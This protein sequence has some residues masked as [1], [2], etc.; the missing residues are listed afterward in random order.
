MVEE[1]DFVELMCRHFV[2]LGYKYRTFE[3]DRTICHE[4]INAISGFI[5][6]IQN[7]WYWTTAKHC[8][9]EIES[10]IKYEKMEVDGY[11]LLDYFGT[12]SSFE[13][14]IP[15]SEYVKDSI[16]VDSPNKV[17]DICFIKLTTNQ[18]EQLEANSIMPITA[19]QD[20]DGL[21]PECTF[22]KMLGLPIGS[23]SEDGDITP[24]LFSI[25]LIDDEKEISKLKNKD[26]DEYYTKEDGLFAIINLGNSQVDIKGTSGGPIYGFRKTE[27]GRMVYTVIA[28]QSKWFKENKIII[29]CPLDTA[30]KA[31]EKKIALFPS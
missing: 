28:I 5:I 18:R 26:T 23:I 27:S 8:L 9:E 4:G 11:W 2:A 22:F 17:L 6:E 15:F 14:G 10:L 31:M 12:D 21:I 30:I 29:G 20:Q 24:Q 3:K 19:V 16:T 25:E 7:I 13:H 1:S